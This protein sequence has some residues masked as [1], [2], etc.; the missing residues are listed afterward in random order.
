MK[1]LVLAAAA[2]LMTA[3]AF[4][5][6]SSGALG[7]IA[8]FNQDL[9]GNEIVRVIEGDAAGISSRSGLI[10]A[11]VH[12]NQDYDGAGDDNLRRVS[13]KTVYSGTPAYGAEIFAQIKAEGLDDE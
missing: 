6:V 5:D 4:A 7:A 1:T 11:Q 3:P 2:T 13:G 10:E 9:S 8:H 12:F